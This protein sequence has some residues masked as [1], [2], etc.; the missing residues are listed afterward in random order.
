M[1]SNKTLELIKK[2]NK[3]IYYLV[4]SFINILNKKDNRELG[5]ILANANED[6]QRDWINENTKLKTKRRDDDDINGS[7]Y[8]LI[9][10]DGLVK[11]N[12]KIRINNLYLENTRRKSAKNSDNSRT[13][14]VA[15]SVG[16]SDIYLFSKPNK[17]DYDN[18]DDWNFIAIPETELIDPNNPKYLVT[19][20][21]KKIEKKYIGKTKETLENI[22]NQKLTK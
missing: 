17:S 21:S 20:I 18:L 10:T 4:L 6:I 12:A 7:G 1:I 22:L 16:E 13:G 19:S 15:Y 8:D 2:E 14:H 9:T 11:I 3:I 5:K